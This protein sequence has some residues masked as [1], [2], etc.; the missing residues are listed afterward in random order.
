MARSRRRPADV[1]IPRAL[2]GTPAA[3]DFACTSG[4][5]ADTLRDSATSPDCVLSSYEDFKKS[6]KAPGD[7]V[8]TG[9]L[10]AGAGLTFIPMV[11]ESHSGGWGKM[12]RKTLDTIAKHAG[13]CWRGEVEVE[14]LRIAQR[15]SCSLHRENARA[16]LRRLQEP[17][18]GEDVGSWSPGDTEPLWQ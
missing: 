11:I 4:L 5:R 3:L 14:S 13:A 16:I 18:L 2:G 10:C 12:A 1:F 8:A 9:E 17:F 6:F 15:L 7:E